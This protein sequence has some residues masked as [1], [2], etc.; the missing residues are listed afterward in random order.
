MSCWG[1]LMFDVW[2]QLITPDVHVLSVSYFSQSELLD[3]AEYK[4][5]AA[6]CI[7]ALILQLGLCCRYWQLSLKC[8]VSKCVAHIMPTR[9]VVCIWGRFV[10]ITLVPS[11]PQYKYIVT[12]AHH[13]LRC[14]KSDYVTLLH[15]GLLATSMFSRGSQGTSRIAKR[16]SAFYS[17]WVYPLECLTQLSSV[18]RTSPLIW[19]D[20]YH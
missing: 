17:Y 19:L 10:N 18:S 13:F 1:K 11:G 3:V 7:A 16:T 14:H 5:Y 8:G 20:Y 9:Y 12:S 15:Y 2:S 4:P 6:T